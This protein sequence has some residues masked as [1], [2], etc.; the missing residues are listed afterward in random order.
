MSYGNTV[1]IEAIVDSS[2]KA[3]N[4]KWKKNDN[5]IHSDGKKIIIDESNKAKPTLTI[6]CLDFDD[7]GNYSISVTN[8]LGSTEEEICINVK[9][10]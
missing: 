4:I 2:P 5:T 3:L 9:G 8:A 6:L 1:T 7:S 10:I